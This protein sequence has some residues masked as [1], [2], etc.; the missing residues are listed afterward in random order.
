MK[1]LRISHTVPKRCKR[2]EITVLNAKESYL[3]RQS[4][5]RYLKSEEH[6]ELQRMAKRTVKVREIGRVDNVR[7]IESP[8]LN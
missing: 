3:Y 8:S 7:F 2:R 6:T 1:W 4:Y 5:Q